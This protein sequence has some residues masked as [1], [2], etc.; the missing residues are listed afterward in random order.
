MTNVVTSADNF[1]F[2]SLESTS[3]MY[4]L[5]DDLLSLDHF[6]HYTCHGFFSMMIPQVSCSVSYYSSGINGTIVQRVLL[7]WYFDYFAGRLAQYWSVIG[8][9]L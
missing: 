7:C 9:S 6:F 1:E 2:M 3:G 8:H 4:I 5:F